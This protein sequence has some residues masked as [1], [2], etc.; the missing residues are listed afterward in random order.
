VLRPGPQ[1]G[2]GCPQTS[3]MIPG[4]Q[5]RRV[6]RSHH[7]GAIA[8]SSAS[9]G[10][11]PYVSAVEFALSQDARPLMLL[12]RLA[13]HTR[14]LL[15][16]PR[17]SLLAASPGPDALAQPRLSLLGEARQLR[18]DSDLLARYLRYFPASH[19]Y[20][21]LGDFSLIAIE[22]AKARYIERFGEITWIAASE[23]LA[24][25]SDLDEREAEL[26]GGASP[27]LLARLARHL[28]PKPDQGKSQA[29]LVGVDC[30]GVDLRIDGRL[31]RADFPEPVPDAQAALQALD[32]MGRTV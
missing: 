29:S 14:N 19:R 10:G 5:A 26:I 12:S 25:P 3:K 2:G 30:D 18:Q 17:V 24:P 22:P 7:W 16:D 1:A 28:A 4:R 23:L 31:L 20:L 21:E 8:T 13:E 11:H 6:L 15:N 27:D 32:A 9:N